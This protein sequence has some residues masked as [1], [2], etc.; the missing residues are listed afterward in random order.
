MIS[1]RWAGLATRMKEGRSAFKILVGKTTR[2]RLLGRPRH[3]S[4]KN[5]RKD[6][7]EIGVNTKNWC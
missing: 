5:I 4:E 2:R 7:Q 6:L 1:G 3:R